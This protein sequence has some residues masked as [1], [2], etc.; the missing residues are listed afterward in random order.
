MD[1]I[2]IN[3]V[4]D[5]LNQVSIEDNKYH[6]T[7]NFPDIEDIF[8]DY[9]IKQGVIGYSFNND[10]NYNDKVNF[11]DYNK[12]SEYKNFSGQVIDMFTQKKWDLYNKKTNWLLDTG[13]LYNLISE[14][15]IKKDLDY[16]NDKEIIKIIAKNEPEG[17]LLNDEKLKNLLEEIYYEMNFEEQI[18]EEKFVNDILKEKEKILDEYKKLLEI[19]E[20]ADYVEVVEELENLDYPTLLEFENVF[21]TD[22]QMMEEYLSDMEYVAKILDELEGDVIN[23]E[24][25]LLNTKEDFI[26]QVLD[27]GE[28]DYTN[29]LLP[30][31]ENLTEE[32][33]ENSIYNYVEVSNSSGKFEPGNFNLLTR[34]MLESKF[35]SFAEYVKEKLKEENLYNEEIEEKIDNIIYEQFD[36]IYTN[37]LDTS[38]GGNEF[39]EMLELDKNWNKEK[40]Y[41]K[42]LEV[43]QEEL[44]INQVQE[45]NIQ[46]SIGSKK[47]DNVNIINKIIEEY[48]DKGYIKKPK[49][50]DKLLDKDIVLNVNIKY[51]GELNTADLE[52]VLKLALSGY[53]PEVKKEIMEKYNNILDIEATGG[54]IEKV[55]RVLNKE[56]KNIQNIKVSE[57]LK[58]I[59][60]ENFIYALEDTIHN[61]E[62]KKELANVKPIDFIEANK[63]LN[64][65]YI[66]KIL[67]NLGSKV[68]R[69]TEGIEVNNKKYNNYFEFLDKN[70]K[71]T[72]RQKRE[73]LK[74]VLELTKYNN[75]EINLNGK[76]HN[77][78]LNNKFLNLFTRYLNSDLENYLE[79]YGVETLINSKDPL[80][81]LLK[82]NINN[83]D[84]NIALT[85]IRTINEIQS[86]ANMNFDEKQNLV[87]LLPTKNGQIMKN[88]LKDEEIMKLLETT[89]NDSLETVVEKLKNS[90]IIMPLEELNHLIP[91]F[92]LN[93]NKFKNYKW[94][95]ELNNILSNFKVEILNSD[96]V[97]RNQ[98]IKDIEVLNNNLSDKMFILLGPSGVGKD[99]I[100]EMLKELNNNNYNFK[101]ENFNKAEKFIIDNLN[102]INNNIDEIID[103]ADEDIKEEVKFLLSIDTLRKR[104]NEMRKVN[105]ELNN[106]MSL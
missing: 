16:K 26:Y 95:K 39:V 53:I 18:D 62:I 57:I 63:D 67:I 75:F 82:I 70:K 101:Y 106:N 8:N 23:K 25:V 79:H 83:S 34:I 41:Q 92:L 20:D 105:Q 103:L 10:I 90:K 59:A 81:E 27:G 11:P 65:K 56:N 100:L 72:Q 80:V 22:N 91:I 38:I 44:D 71:L 29:V 3:N 33:K 1:Y 61:E 40:Y 15:A 60:G 104:F 52:N 4:F 87:V 5:I 58:Q 7:K 49:N 28:L 36:N 13:L 74:K 24:R 47:E 43:F 35:L 102:N 64:E 45:K 73:V 77:I 98:F 66:R 76:F 31:W 85:D 86:I 68:F 94:A 12:N 55:N 21:Y 46:I 17:I 69:K 14:Y 97:N 9:I 89:K 42:F 37:F 30:I 93:K 84:N 19:I 99:T 50:P 32:E 88:K 54:N 2:T 6:N 51:D 78:D 96:R 48:Q